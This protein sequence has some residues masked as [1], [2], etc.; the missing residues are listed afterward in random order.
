[1][2]LLPLIFALLL[3]AVPI[4]AHADVEVGFW[5]R[6][7]GM[8]LPHAFIT[9]RGTIDGAPVDESYG[10]TAKAMTPAILWGPVPGR[11]DLTSKVYIARSN[12]IFTVRADDAGYARLKA[13]IARWSVRPGSIYRVNDRNCVHFVGEAAESLGLKMATDKR[14][15][16]RPT[17]FLLA[18][19]AANPGIATLQVGAK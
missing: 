2:R 19:A 14:L 9:I 4:A 7:L 11:I 17:S 6:E 3:A 1:M 15:M 10:F 8:Q 12:A 18:V 5:S 16:K 13:L